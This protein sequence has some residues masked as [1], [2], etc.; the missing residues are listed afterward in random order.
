MRRRSSLPVPRCGNSSTAKNWFGRGI[1]RFGRPVC[2]KL[3]EHGFQF[4]RLQQVQD[5]EALALFPVGHGCDDEFLFRGAGKFVQLLFDFDVRHHL[6]ADFAEA[7]QAIGD[8]EE[9]V[10]VFGGD[11]AGDVPAVLQHLR[12]F[13][14]LA[15]IALASRWARAPAAIRAMPAGIA[16]A[17][18]GIDDAHADA[19]AADARCARASP[20]TCRKPGARKSRVFTA[21]TGE[22]SVAP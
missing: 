16:L 2:G 12:R 19:R 13:F 15:E 10:F 8:R 21:T 1:H 7:A 20:P 18:F 11:V 6:A 5:D 22:H 14:G 17:R 4:L 3:F 9:A